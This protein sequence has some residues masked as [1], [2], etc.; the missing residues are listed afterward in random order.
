MGERNGHNVTPHGDCAPLKMRS[1][2]ARAL[3]DFRRTWPQLVAADLLARAIGLV[4]T[5]PVIGLFLELFL[6]QTEDQVLTDTDIVVFFLHPIGLLAF[7]VIGTLWMGMALAR[8]GLLMTI[9]LGATEDRRVSYLD[10]LRYIGARAGG[11]GRLGGRTFGRLVLTCAPFLAGLGAVYVLL[12]TDHDINYYLTT[13]PPEFL[14]A[15]G[16]AL[17][18]MAALLVLLLRA[19]AEW[20]LAL[21]VLLFEGL[22][23][24]EALRRSQR[25]TAPHRWKITFF[26]AGWVMV[27]LLFSVFSLFLIGLLGRALLP[28]LRGNWFLVLAGLATTLAAGA[29]IGLAIQVFSASLLPLVVVRWYRDLGASGRTVPWISERG[30]LGPRAKLQ[31]PGKWVLV[32]S[33]TAAVLMITAGY[34]GARALASGDSVE[35]IAHRGSSRSAPENTMAAFERAHAELASWIELDVQENLEGEVI[36]VHDSDFMKLAGVRL[37]VWD[38]TNEDLLDLDVG[39]WFG[40]EHAD[41]RLPRLRDV[42]VWARGRIGVVIEL[43]YYGHDQD[44]ESRV[45]DLVEQTGMESEVMLMSL[46]RKGLIRVAELRPD[47]TRGLLNTA[48]IGDLTRVNVHFLALNAAAATRRQIRKAHERGMKVY[49]WTIND[50]VQMAVMLSRGADGLITDEPAVARKVIEVREALS[51]LGHLLVWIAGETGLL[52]GTKTF[53]NVEDA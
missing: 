31:L 21:P 41:E 5:I 43:K 51:P 9:G 32:G 23:A 29:M 10:G 46:D 17:L 39:S 48:S 25:M 52:E 3:G 44:L 18:L 36:V 22:G 38:A 20:T 28:D 19:G 35:I 24:S 49:V 15:V 37:K 42:L 8:V 4:I 27:A 33:A 47:W 13:R 2:L 16:L 11:L 30:V 34:A 50:P 7:A 14:T 45:V 12:L 1:A 53:S 6:F 40:P 26:V